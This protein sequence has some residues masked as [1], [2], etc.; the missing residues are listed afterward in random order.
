MSEKEMPKRNIGENESKIDLPL[1]LVLLYEIPV[2]SS[3]FKL[4]AC[5]PVAGTYLLSTMA[6]NIVLNLKQLC[7]LVT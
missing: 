5:R 7:S 3:V 2:F 6:Y 1:T 4:G